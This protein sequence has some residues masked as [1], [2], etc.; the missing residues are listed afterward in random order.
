MKV[1]VAAAL[2]LTMASAC[3]SKARS[4]AGTDASL[5]SGAVGGAGD[6]ALDRSTDSAINRAVGDSGTLLA[7]LPLSE[8][9]A[10]TQTLFWGTLDVSAPGIAI[11]PKDQL[12]IGLGPDNSLRYLGWQT[13]PGLPKTYGDGANDFPLSGTRAVDLKPGNA[14]VFDE[15]TA[16]D[17]PA[18]TATHFL[19]RSHY[20]SSGSN[21]DFIE[22]VEGTRSKDGWAIVYGEQ[23]TLFAAS[24][25]VNAVGTVYPRDEPS[26]RV[27]TLGQPSLWSAPVEL[28][29][30][31][32]PGPPVDHL[33]LALD[34][35]GKIQWFAF[36]NFVRRVSFATS[37]QNLPLGGS[38]LSEEG[39]VSF[40]SVVAPSQAHVVTRYQVLSD[41][42]LNDFTEG[43]DSTRKGD[44]VMV[45]YFISGTLRGTPIEAHAAGLLTPAS[46]TTIDGG[47]AL[48]GA[49]A[50]AGVDA[51]IG[52]DAAL[53]GSVAL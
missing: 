15:V 34:G 10:A 49:R 21:C 32:F 30:P 31:G 51:A 9:P 45:R 41:T 52:T 35:T 2:Y 7:M 11:P 43:F 47:T 20:V 5:G 25:T 36:Q 12:T 24:I 17:S 19:L 29:A 33:T 28:V 18:P 4:N 27:A 1:L 37:S 53:D 39:T 40:D 48:D 8:A 50:S 3:G 13:V 26:N 16:L 22:S 44:S 42:T 46:V 6:D 23:G 14:V 38:L